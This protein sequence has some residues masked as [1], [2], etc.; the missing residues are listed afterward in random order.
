MEVKYMEEKETKKTELKISGMSCAT[1]AV[2]IENS[3]SQLE[4]VH[5]AK[6]NLGSETAIVEYEP[7]KVDLS[8]MQEAV[9]SAGYEVINDTVTLKIGGMTCASCVRTIENSVGKLEGVAD[10]NVNLAAEKAFITFNP[11]MTGI[12]DIKKAVQDAGYEVLG[13][14]GEED[15]MEKSMREKDL[16]KKLNR[17]IIG[18]AVGVPMMF[19]PYMNIPFPVPLSYILLVI[20]LP[21]FIYLSQPIFSAAYHSLINRNLSMDV[22]YSMGIGVAFVASILGTFQIVLSREFLFYD[23]AILLATF[24]MMGRYLEARAKG[25]TS[26]AIKKL[27]G[28]QPKTAIVI[29]E[30]KEMELPIEDVVI[31]DSI[32]VKPGERIPVDGVVEDGESYVNEAMITGEPVPV[33]KKSGDDVIGGTIN[34]NSVLKFRATKVGKDTVLARIIKLVEEAQGSKPPVQRV[35]DKAVVYFIPAVLGIAIFSFLAWYFIAGN[36]LLF[37]L[38]ALI[39]VLVIACPCALGLAT[40]TAVTVGV[41]RGAE[42]GILI[43]SG[44]ALEI[45]EKITTVI[46]DK[47]GTLTEGKPDVVNIISYGISEEELL[48][49]A[50]G[51]EKNSEHPLGKAVMKKAEEDGI[52]AA[53]VK[54]F[55]ALSGKGVI[56]KVG[57]KEIVVGNRMLFKERG[58]KYPEEVGKDIV[59]LEKEGKTVI[60]VAVDGRVSGLIAIADRVKESAMKTVKELGRMG[61]KVA[62]ITGDNRRTAEAVAKQ[63]GID[64]VM[65][66]V[67]PE[68]KSNNVKKLQSG[69][70]IVAF[71]GDGINDAPALAQADV[72]IAVGSGTDIAM[73]SGDIVLMKDELT[74]VVAAIE[75]GRKVM[76]RIKQNLFWAFAYNTALIPVAAGLLY[77]MYGI[78]FRPEFAGLAMAMSSVTVVSFS[79]LLKRYVPSIK[80]KGEGA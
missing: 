14:E 59:K 51:I 13:V 23:T 67:L 10:I 21:V 57:E 19:L 28:L 5:I 65:A 74:D 17:I 46:F 4:G 25:K 78:T 7:E 43:K 53:E 16:K 1:C 52:K 64:H 69:G 72:G 9:K 47:T 8:E 76:A 63:L 49:L 3:L 77:S 62:M 55:N 6:V 20:S 37:S 61:I 26:E 75:L 44:D 32:V 12:S 24:L 35:A 73:E 31:G 42:L 29:R 2:S 71:V 41:G 38:T 27:M 11:K 80:K 18:F 79:L 50:A 40:P 15:D 33:L 22:M 30:G 54:E 39:S 70:E 60:M 66:E 68:D 45:S 48:A 34:T 56:G 58:L 36:T